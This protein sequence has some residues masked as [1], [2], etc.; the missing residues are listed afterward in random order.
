MNIF[1]KINGEINLQKT[2]KI[3]FSP[4]NYEMWV[5]KC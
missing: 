4:D 2:S 1:R 5:Q 3:K